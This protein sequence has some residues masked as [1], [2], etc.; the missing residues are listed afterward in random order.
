[1][2]SISKR[3]GPKPY[4]ARYRGPD[5]REVSRAFTRKIDAQKWL[6]SQQTDLIRGEWVDPKAGSVTF[7]EW[8]AHVSETRRGIKDSTRARDDSYLRSL[9]LPTFGRLPLSAIT[10]EHFDQWIAGLVAAGKAPATISKAYQITSAILDQ[11]VRRQ[12]LAA[13]PARLRTVELPKVTAAEMRFLQPEQIE[14]LVA[15]VPARDR[16]LVL[17]AAYAGLRWG[18]AAALDRFAIDLPG[19]ALTVSRSLAEVAGHLSYTSPKTESSKRR[20]SLPAFL[21]GE[22]AGHLE[23]YGG[24]G[25]LVFTTAT[26]LPMRRTNWRRRVWLPAV[27]ATVGQPMRF[28]DLRHSHAAMLIAQGAHPKVIQGRLGHSKI[29]TTLDTYGHLWDGLD[30]AAADTLDELISGARSTVAGTGNLAAISTSPQR[31]RGLAG[32]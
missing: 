12:K 8:A 24:D 4:L 10:P 15:A 20:I 14:A 9:I 18:E 11:A 23:Q 17:T 16:V 6:T 7:A 21:V 1:M 28:H 2:A 32:D 29:A 27:T 30:E 25:G 19:R 26:G 22:L 31:K 13:S 5:R 3:P